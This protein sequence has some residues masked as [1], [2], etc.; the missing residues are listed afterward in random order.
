MIGPLP[1]RLEHVGRDDVG[2]GVNDRR[3]HDVS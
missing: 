2:V 3:R 1:Q